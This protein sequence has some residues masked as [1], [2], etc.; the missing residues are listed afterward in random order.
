MGSSLQDL[1]RFPDD[2]RADAGY[3]LHLVQVG[4]EP[5]DWRPMPIV[6]PGAVEIR[7]HSAREDRVIF[8]ARFAE[9]IYVLHA[10]AKSTRQTRTADL[11][12]AR[13]RLRETLETRRVRLT[14]PRSEE[15]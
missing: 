8:V 10:F 14:Q 13:T 3:A 1:R 9:A 7:V 5:P 6:G 12:L 15:R 2:A 4:Q 11:Q